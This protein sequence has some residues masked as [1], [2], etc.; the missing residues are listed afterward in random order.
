[1][2]YFMEKKATVQ[3]LMS[4]YNGEKYL[5]QQVDSILNQ[6]NVDVHLLIRDDGSTDG[7]V[8]VIQK[9]KKKYN[10]KIEYYKGK[11]VGYKKSFLDLTKNTDKN[12]DFFAF[13]DQDDYWMPQKLCSAIN[14]LTNNL[15]SIQLYASTVIITDENLKPLYKKD[16]SDFVNSFGSS[17]SRI[18]LAGCT[19]VFNGKALEMLNKFDWSDIPNK[20]MPSHDGLLMTICQAVNGYVYVDQEAYL[21]HRRRAESVTSGGNGILKR[22]NNERKMMFDCRNDKS[23]LSLRIYDTFETQLSPVNKKLINEVM[24][25]KDSLSNRLR[26]VKNKQLNCGLKLG[27]LETKIRIMT[28]YF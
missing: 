12:F 4:T 28:G 19:Y 5:V 17:L 21:L 27:N 15:N 10:S 6:Q 11:N 1:M 18:R 20:E 2:E 22:I 24:N 23:T 8:D 25:Y 9:L 14:H 7:S 16:I 13:A 26:L 3:V